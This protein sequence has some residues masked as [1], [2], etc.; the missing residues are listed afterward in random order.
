MSPSQGVVISFRYRI[1]SATGL[2]QKMLRSQASLVLPMQPSPLLR[3]FGQQ[4]PQTQIINHILH[5][6]N[7]I[8]YPITPLPQTIILQIQN[9]E[10]R[11]HILNKLS[12]LLRSLIIPKRDTIPR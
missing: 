1:R 11:M 5:L 10:P 12:N 4:P 3:V 9:L 8:L 6:L 2:S 7:P